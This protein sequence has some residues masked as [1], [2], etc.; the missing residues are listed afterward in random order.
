MKLLFLGAG[1]GLGTDSKN[2]QSNMLL[3]TDKGKKLLIDCG[4]D[5]RFS[6]AR[7]RYISHDI[8]AVYIS[9]LHADHIG[10]IEWLAFQRKF[11]VESEPPQLIIHEHLVDLLWSHSLSGGL[12]TLN[13]K[14]ATLN[15]YFR[16]TTVNDGQVFQWEGLHFNLIKTVHIHSNRKLMPS[17]GLYIKYQDK[18]F[19]ITTDTQFTPERFEKYYQEATLIFHDCETLEVPSGVHAH[20]SQLDTLAPEIKAKL[21]LYH[22]NDGKL[23]DAQFHGFLGFVQCGQII[24]LK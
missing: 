9:H 7:A 14:E 5:I 10:G 21:W 6:L 19:F 22:Y 17:Y 11:A 3:L 13:E 16:V 20:F 4:T 24:E 18:N 1:S 15:D 12:K 2:F 23:P 8:D